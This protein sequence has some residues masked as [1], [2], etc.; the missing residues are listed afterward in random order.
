MSFE[1]SK[2]TPLMLPLFGCLA[3][4]P[5]AAILAAR[6]CKVCGKPIGRR[7][8]FW[9]LT[10]AKPDVAHVS[11]LSGSAPIKTTRRE[12]SSSL[13]SR[14]CGNATAAGPTPRPETQS[15]GDGAESRA[16]AATPQERKPNACRQTKHG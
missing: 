14:S 12:R 2:P 15:K 13:R 16:G 11:C 7:V 9:F 3:D 4:W 6:P 5:Y 1:Q 10:V 8:E